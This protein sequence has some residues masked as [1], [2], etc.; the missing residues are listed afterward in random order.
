MS[1]SQ[2]EASLQMERMVEHYLEN[3]TT[4]QNK[5]NLYNNAPELEIR[6]GT[7]PKQA[8]PIS[9]V[10][11]LHVVSVLYANG[12]KPSDDNP[13]GKQFLLIIP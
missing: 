13:N 3:C 4:V 5:L 11:Y 8:K 10:D 1:E 9:K 6:F 2:K 7:N 12:W